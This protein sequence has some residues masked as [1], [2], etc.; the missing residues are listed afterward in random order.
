MFHWCMLFVAIVAE[1]L[2]TMTL[3]LSADV[4]PVAGH[5]AMVALIAASFYFLAIAVRRVPMGVA[6]AVWEGLGLVL[7]TVVSA[8]LFD[9]ALGRRE[10]SAFA[11]ILAGVWLLQRAD[12]TGVPAA[13][14]SPPLGAAS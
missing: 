10:W 13:G 14:G 12:D 8:W 6:Y 1:V 3:R 4:A 5:V 2:G 7:I 11:L 9:D